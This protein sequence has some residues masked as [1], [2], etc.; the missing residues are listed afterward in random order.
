VPE[1]GTLALVAA[2]LALAAGRRRVLR[3]N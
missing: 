2:G 3:K 1:P